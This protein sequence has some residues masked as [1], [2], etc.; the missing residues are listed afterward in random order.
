MK[1]LY[2]LIETPRGTLAHLLKHDDRRE[3]V[4]V[5]TTIMR[6]ERAAVYL[7]RNSYMMGVQRGS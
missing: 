4:H 1:R 2:I 5:F 6:H 7:P 3:C